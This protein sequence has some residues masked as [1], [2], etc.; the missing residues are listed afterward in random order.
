MANSK[1]Q[2]RL[3]AESHS[4]DYKDCGNGHIQLSGHGVQVNYWP[5]S[6]NMTAHIAG[7]KTVKHCRP[8]D[9][10]KLCMTNGKT[11]LKVSKKHVTK[12][13]PNFEI[14]SITTNPAGLVHFYSGNIPPWE[15]DTVI[16]CHSDNLRLQAMHI[17]DKAD[18]LDN[19]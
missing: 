12:N 7:G 11:E 8:F 5:E 17:R 15:F 9:A 14:K 16:R 2:T 19:I 6:K 10:I 3:L 13:G 1:D 4:I 18:I